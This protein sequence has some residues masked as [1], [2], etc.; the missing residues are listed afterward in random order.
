MLSG[1]SSVSRQLNNNLRKGG[2]KPSSGVFM[3]LVLSI[4]SVIVQAE[5]TRLHLSIKELKELAPNMK[6]SKKSLLNVKIESEAW[7]ERKASLDDPCEPWERTPIYVSC[8]AWFSGPPGTK[9]RVDI[10]QEVLEWKEGFAPYV[11]RSYSLAFDGQHGRVVNHTM[12]YDDKTLFIKNGES[13][14]DSPI[15]LKLGW[16]G[17]F[18]GIHFSYHFSAAQRGYPFSQVIQMAAEDSNFATSSEFEFVWEKIDGGKKCLRINSGTKKKNRNYH[19]YLLDP[20]RGF[21]LL[22]AKTAHI[23]EDGSEQVISSLKVSKLR[24]VAAAIWWPVEASIERPSTDPERPYERVVYRASD[25]IAN[26][27]NFDENVYTVPFPKGYLVD[28]KVKGIK[29][30]AGQEQEIKEK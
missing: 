16:V 19:S 30:R 27:P 9:A 11:D 2:L 3:L 17:A 18:T 23:S 6:A 1:V 29:Y 7:V 25:V 12:K 24:K 13:I 10:H 21:A 22:E 14:A 5:Q 4:M 26:D 8:T 20:S 15:G 28:D